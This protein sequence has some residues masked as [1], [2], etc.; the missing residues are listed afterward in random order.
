M[1]TTTKTPTTTKK[2]TKK[3]GAKGA[4]PK[5]AD[6]AATAAKAA[7]APGAAPKGKKPTQAKDGAKGG[8]WIAIDFTNDYKANRD[9][10]ISS[11][12]K[13][14]KGVKCMPNG[15]VPGLSTGSYG[16]HLASAFKGASRYLL[17]L[18]ANNLASLRQR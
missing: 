13:L 16:T 6:K 9:A 11:S 7:K 4:K 18:D 17:G 15:A 12:S 1:A 8:K 5:A 3:A 14:V 10:P 2:T